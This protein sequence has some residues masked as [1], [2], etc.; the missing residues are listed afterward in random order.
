[1]AARPAG[2]LIRDDGHGETLINQSSSAPFSAESS[3]NTRLAA[4]AATKPDL[5]VFLQPNS[6]RFTDPVVGQYQV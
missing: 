2:R 3:E 1:M 6:F 5:F 4:G